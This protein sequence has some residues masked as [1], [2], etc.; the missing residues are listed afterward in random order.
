MWEPIGLGNMGDL[1]TDE[2]DLKLPRTRA[3]IMKE[4]RLVDGG[5]QRGL[6]PNTPFS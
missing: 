1:L 4:E 3:S 5:A 6:E 2:C